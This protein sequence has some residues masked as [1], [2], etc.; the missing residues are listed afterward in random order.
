MGSLLRFLLYSDLIVLLGIFFSLS[1]QLLLEGLDACLK[2]LHGRGGLCELRR[3]CQ[4]PGEDTRVSKCVVRKGDDLLAANKSRFGDRSDGRDRRNIKCWRRQLFD[5]GNWRQKC[6]WFDLRRRMRCCWRY[7][8]RYLN[9]RD[10][11][12]R[13]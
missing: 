9:W 10:R 4:C 8:R 13:R 2:S 7:W 1:C 12:R 11:L 5:D 6:R 3:I